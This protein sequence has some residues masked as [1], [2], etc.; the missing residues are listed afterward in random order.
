[1]FDRAR[2]ADVLDALREACGVGSIREVS[3]ESIAAQA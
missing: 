3:A 1:M 2:R